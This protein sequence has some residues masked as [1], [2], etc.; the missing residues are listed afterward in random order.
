MKLH[1]RA[2]AAASLLCAVTAA[3]NA[4]SYTAIL[5]GAKEAPP[6]S[7]PAVG[8]AVVKFDVATHE[9]TISTAFLSLIGDT[10]AA[11]IHCCTATPGVDVAGV[12]TET[13]TF[14]GFPLGVQIGAYNHIY[15][16]SLASS[17][18]GAFLS[19]NGGTTAG[20]EAAFLAGLNAG[21]AYLNIH[22]TAY[23]A[24]EIRGFLA[25]APV[26]E[27][28]A[29]AMLSLGLPALMLVARRRRKPAAT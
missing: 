1:T 4:A 18:N 8:A 3:A 5:G 27:P 11:H 25:I 26:P 13:P 24:G 10:T 2:W 6:N 17:W 9:L 21:A 28:G 16:T 22:T 23:P 12:A 29:S 20:A 19:A 15:D 14:G 7:S